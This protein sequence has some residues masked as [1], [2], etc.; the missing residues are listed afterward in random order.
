MPKQ[1]FPYKANVQVENSY[2]FG[3]LTSGVDLTRFNKNPIVL[4]NHNANVPVGTAKDLKINGNDAEVIVEIDD[5]DDAELQKV[6]RDINKRLYQGLSMSLDLNFQSVK[7]GV[8]GFP[9]TL[10]V[11]CLSELQELSI[12]P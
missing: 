12:T 3:V 10:P 6:C 11:F 9:P 5:T 7:F 8:E 4:K 1:E 2:G